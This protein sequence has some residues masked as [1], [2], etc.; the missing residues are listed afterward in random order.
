[1][2]EFCPLCNKRKQENGVFCD[3]CKSKFETE[4]EVRVPDPIAPAPLQSEPTDGEV[5]TE[6]N[7][8]IPIGFTSIPTEEEKKKPRKR[9]KQFIAAFIVLLLAVGGF[10]F[11]KEIIR[12][13]NLDSSKWEWAIREN[14]TT[15]Y[16]SYMEEF[17][18]GKHYSEA[19]TKMMELKEME[20]SLYQKM[21]Q[22]E[23]TAELRDFITTNSHSP[24]IPLI[25]KRLDSL[26]WVATLNDNTAESYS[27]YMVL[28]QSGEFDG[29]YFSDA[30]NRY[31]LLFQSYPVTK[32]ELD[33]V[34][35]VVDGFFDALSTV[36]ADKISNYLA[37]KVFTFFNSS[38]GTREKIVGDLIIDGS[39]KQAP[40][41]KF[42]PNTQ[43]LAYEKTLVEHY[44]VNVPIQK[45]FLD[46]EGKRK[47][48][49]GYIVEM[50]LNKDF[51]II[52]INEI[53]P[54]HE[55]P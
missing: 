1:M 16:L 37:D 22:S 19:E 11:Y 33:S 7:E 49:D 21:E 36:K 55:A 28:S 12:K 38:G 48:I 26:T 43:A 3:D 39:K 50:E 44:K 53:K 42:T 6:N 31:D 13:G 10:Y 47:N 46:K 54:F 35:M 25:K 9:K 20:T 27:K 14:T 8:S 29:D 51:K 2:S 17:P 23:N 5:Q 52:I 32:T 24:Y 4:Y 41:I 40:T 34:K 18:K 45:S 15:G 30:K